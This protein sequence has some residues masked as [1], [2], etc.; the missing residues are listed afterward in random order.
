[1]LLKGQAVRGGEQKQ[2]PFVWRAAT[3]RTALRGDEQNRSPISQSH[4]QCQKA[5]SVNKMQVSLL[6]PAVFQ[7]APPLCQKDMLSVLE[8]ETPQF[9]GEQAYRK[10]VIQWGTS[11]DIWV[12]SLCLAVICIY[13]LMIL[14]V[15]WAPSFPD[16]ET[17]YGCVSE[18]EQTKPNRAL[19]S[20]VCM[21]SLDASQRTGAGR[22]RIEK[23]RITMWLV[24]QTHF[25]LGIKPCIS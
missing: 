3:E 24:M 16:C 25:H 1:M 6:P 8:H 12:F 2:T 13:S 11:C 23:P 17:S 4:Q 20:Y 5:Q 19:K 10:L 22:D 18:C 15:L 7:M 21:F 9:W 14:S